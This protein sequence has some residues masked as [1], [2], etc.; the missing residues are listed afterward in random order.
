[1]I[2]HYRRLTAGC[3]RRRDFAEGAGILRIRI[4]RI[5][6]SLPIAVVLLVGLLK[7][8]NVEQ[9]LKWA[10][11]N[12]DAHAMTHHVDPP[13]RSNG[14]KWQVVK[15][16]GCSMELKETLHREAQDSVVNNEG[17][18][19]FAE[20]KAV[21]WTFDLSNLLPQFIM[22]DTSVGAPH[23]KIFAEGDAFH[24]KTE[25]VSRL[26]KKDGS[27]QSTSAWSTAGSAR[28]LEMFFDSPL[29]DNK[30]VVRRVATDLRDAATQC[31][32]QASVR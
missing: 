19:G 16:D 11:E 17:V 4:M 26:M 3:E 29:T 18:F 25:S 12:I 9:T 22:A 10:R 28:I 2:A 13:A 24:T 7:A 23:V 20:D 21:T 1:M 32:V 5:M 8:Q 30:V 27:T 6:S 15:I 14:T 31:S